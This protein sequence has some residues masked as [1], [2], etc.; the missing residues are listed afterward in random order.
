[1]RVVEFLEENK[2][3]LRVG[4]P[5]EL[6]DLIDGRSVYAGSYEAMVEGLE[7]VGLEHV[8]NARFVVE[9]TENGRDRIV[10]LY[11]KDL[12]KYD[13]F[14]LR[15]FAYKMR[16][17][18]TREESL[19]ERLCNATEKAG[20]VVWDDVGLGEIEKGVIDMI[21]DLILDRKDKAFDARVGLDEK[22]L[23]YNAHDFYMACRS[24]G[25]ISDDIT[26]AMDGG[27]EEE[28]KA[29]LCKY[30]LE[31]EYNPVICDYIQKLD[32]L[33]KS[34][35]VIEHAAAQAFQ[36]ACLEPVEHAH[37]VFNAVFDGALAF[38]S[39]E[40]K[41]IDFGVLSKNE[42]LASYSY[43]TEEEYDA[44]VRVA[45]EMEKCKSLDTKLADAVER[46]DSCSESGFG[47][48]CH[49]KG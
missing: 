27:T 45:A 43:L 35:Y 8:R 17:L 1:M 30:I 31:N 49:E 38:V 28:V 29:A 34:H 40:E 7:M 9:D 48:K 15:Q 39:D 21:V 32:W 47:K 37:A 19:E 23:N 41:M 4:L 13:D 16:R 22:S 3:N 26:K 46:S 2:S 18:E 44:T 11:M 5:I 20:C 33:S 14:D 6:L 10:L 24:Y 36:A 12:D 25:R 42:F